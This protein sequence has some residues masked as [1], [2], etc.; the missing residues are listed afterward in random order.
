[1]I[2]MNINRQRRQIEMRSI[3]TDKEWFNRHFQTIKLYSIVNCEFRF[4][5]QKYKI[6]TGQSVFCSNTDDSCNSVR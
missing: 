1:M 3:I 5:I 2:F 6:V 4:P